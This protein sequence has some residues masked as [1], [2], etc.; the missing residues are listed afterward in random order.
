MRL[1]THRILAFFVSVHEGTAVRLPACVSWKL[2]FLSRFDTAM[3]KDVL[4]TLDKIGH[5]SATLVSSA[6]SRHVSE[7]K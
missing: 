6:F 5:G 3:D 7:L 1:K 4:K 2:R